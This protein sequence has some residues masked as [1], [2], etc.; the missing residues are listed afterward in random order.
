VRG[1]YMLLDWG[2]QK[3][4]PIL[5]VIVFALGAW[6]DDSYAQTVDVE[7]RSSTKSAGPNDFVTHTFEIMNSGVDATFDLR[8]DLP[9][10]MM[11]IGF[12]NSIFVSGGT[13]VPLFVTILVTNQAL[14]NQNEIILTVTSQLDANNND[15]AIAIIEVLEVAEISV[16][17][18]NDIQAQVGTTVDVEFVLS[19]RGNTI[20]E[21]QIFAELAPSVPFD[22]NPTQATLQA[23]ESIALV[24][25]IDIPVELTIQFI[26]ITL[27]VNSVLFPNVTAELN[28]RVE[29]LP[30]SSSAF[31]TNLN[32]EIPIEALGA[33]DPIVGI[34]SNPSAPL[35]L[36]TEFRL[37]PGI[38]IAFFMRES[39]LADS[40]FFPTFSAALDFLAASLVLDTGG[41]ITAVLDFEPFFLTV[42][43]E[44]NGS[45]ISGRF[46]APMS[47]ISLSGAFTLSTVDDGFPETSG[48][49]SSTLANVGFALGPLNMNLTVLQNAPA[50]FQNSPDQLSL[51]LTMS[52]GVAGAV[53]VFTLGTDIENLL[54]DPTMSSVTDTS[55]GLRARL[56]PGRNAPT[57]SAEIEYEQSL[58]QGPGGSFDVNNKILVLSL[59]VSQRVLSLMD[60]NLFSDHSLIFNAV[61]NQSFTVDRSAFAGEVDLDF[62]TLSLEL[63]RDRTFDNVNGVIIDGENRSTA[64][65]RAILNNLSFDMRLSRNDIFGLNEVIV[66][67][68]SVLSSSVNVLF[69]N[70]SISTDANL[71][72]GEDTGLIGAGIGLSFRSVFTIPTPFP[73][74]GQVEG[75]VFVDFNENGIRDIDEPGVPNVVVSIGDFNVLSDSDSTDEPGFYRSPP[76]D[77]G[78]YEINLVALRNT[79]VP[80]TELPVL[81]SVIEGQRRFV[82]IPVLPIGGIDG[83]VFNDLDRDGQQDADEPGLIGLAVELTGGDLERPF[84]LRVGENGIF[85][86]DDLPAGEYVVTLDVNTLPNRFEL[87]SPAE[88]VVNLGIGQRVLVTF[89]AFQRPREILFAP[90]ADFSFTPSNPR[91]GQEVTFDASLTF[92]FD[93]E[94]VSYEWDFDND[95]VIDAEGITV[96]HIFE[97]SGQFEVTMTA[98]DDDGLEGIRGPVLIIVN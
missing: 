81:F 15:I 41:R 93:G 83:V 92:D 24:I 87:T 40:S 13:S 79:L 70:F 94:V 77:P 63:Q 20:N 28:A 43:V 75:V 44:Q 69:D 42:L 58:G 33:V 48:S 49:T 55:A 97:T 25:S 34:M 80:G 61:T 52:T 68:E 10:G 17:E 21:F 46:S 47:G 30:P 88:V 1:L 14:A 53:T 72:F 32:L 2:I 38:D 67:R 26:N 22:L 85:N 11:S 18:P 27:Q 96:T 51:G 57:F 19:N 98:T 35:D 54:K 56:D 37:P 50:R 9:V 12:P 89:G 62:L 82:D 71:Q 4:L 31:S 91:A 90:A 64:Q 29:L 86:F 66:D 76:I 23:G 8:L 84:R 65:I 36:S 7:V 39:D 60:V 95:G 45:D 59:N 73:V 74:K 6:S 78:A 16:N 3:S 5:L